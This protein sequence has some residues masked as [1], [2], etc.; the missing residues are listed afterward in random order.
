MREMIRTARQRGLCCVALLSWVRYIGFPVAQIQ[1]L[2]DQQC[3]EITE[4]I[5]SKFS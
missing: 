1:D 5:R 4:R 2:T 3:R